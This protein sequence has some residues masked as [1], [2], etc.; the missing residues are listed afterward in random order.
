MEREHSKA[1]GFFKSKLA[2]TFH[3]VTKRS[4]PMQCVSNYKVTSAPTSAST[5]SAR[6]G[7]V[8]YSLSRHQDLPNVSPMQRMTMGSYKKPMNSY[9]H[10][11][12]LDGGDENVDM[13]AAKYILHVRERLKQERSDANAF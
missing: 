9:H 5:P 6:K 13:M 8:S 12:C 10:N 1:K 3:K 7:S 2:K 4:W 11:G